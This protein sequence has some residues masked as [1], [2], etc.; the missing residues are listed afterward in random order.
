[1][2]KK[3]DIDHYWGELGQKF[4]SKYTKGIVYEDR[5]KPIGE[6]ISK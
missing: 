2:Q 1:M 6:R 4:V 5:S 3:P